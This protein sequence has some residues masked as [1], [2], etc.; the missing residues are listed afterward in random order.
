MRVLRSSRLPAFFAMLVF[1]CISPTQTSAQTR[2]K[3]HEECR[4]LVPTD[5][6]PNFGEEWHQHESIYWGCRLGVP[7]QSVQSWQD[8]FG[9]IQDIR[10][11]TIKEQEF[12]FVEHMEGT[13]HCYSFKAFRKTERGWEEVWQQASEFYCMVA[14]PPIRM[15]IIASSVILQAPATSDKRCTNI[16]SREQYRWNG[17]SFEEVTPQK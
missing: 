5:W 8:P 3:S 15:T 6:G 17:K 13:M 11:A 9:M 12:V 7:P 16:F 4:K 2:R 1:C 10:F 14:C